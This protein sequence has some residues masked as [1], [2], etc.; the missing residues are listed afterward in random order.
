MAQS[1]LSMRKI[2]DV[3][4]LSAAG[5]S[6]RQIAASLGIGPTAAGA[7]LRRAREAGI[8]WPLP[9]DLGDDAL[10][11]HLYPAPAV[12]KDWRSLPDWPGVHRELRRKGV[13]LQ[14]V[15]EEYRATH[16]DGYG[17]SRFCEL[18]RAWEGRLSAT[19]RQ[20]HVAGEKLFVDYAGTTIDIFDATTG[21]V[22]ACQLFVAA[23]G[24]SSYTYAEATAT[25]S[26]PDWIGSLRAAF[27]GKLRQS[28]P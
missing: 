3:L 21:E 8:S 14:L 7:C 1:R 15:W 13:T 5:L 23:L 19:M 16:P 20:A 27:W 2:R 24:G 25:Q 10:E 22:N 9:D 18:Y 17:R 28:H 26:L 4:R 12:P 6:K 11:H